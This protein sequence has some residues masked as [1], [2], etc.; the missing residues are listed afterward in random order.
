[1]LNAPDP[2]METPA[3]PGQQVRPDGK[4]AELGPAEVRSRLCRIR[5]EVSALAPV[6][7]TP[8]GEKLLHDLDEVIE[9]AGQVDPGP[10]GAME[11][12]SRPVAALPSGPDYPATTHR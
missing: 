12:E 2:Q 11:Y 9:S 1:M 3:H 6:R 8:L 10:V 7:D 4:P 5:S